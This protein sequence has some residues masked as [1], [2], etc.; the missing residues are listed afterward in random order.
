MSLHNL[1]GP[2]IVIAD[3]LVVRANWYRAMQIDGHS[4]EQIVHNAR[5]QNK[6]SKKL[7]GVFTFAAKLFIGAKVQ[8][9]ISPTPTA[10]TASDYGKGLRSYRKS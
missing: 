4:H 5:F 3:G 7:T 6:M 8:K 10:L 1:V 2:K 9:V